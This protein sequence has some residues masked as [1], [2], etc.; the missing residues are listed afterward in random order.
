MGT[1][2][3]RMQRAL[4]LQD[5]FVLRAEAHLDHEFD[6][7][8]TKEN[9]GVQIKFATNEDVEHFEL[10][11][12]SNP[13]QKITVLR[14]SIDTGVRFV[15]LGKEVDEKPLVR[16][17]ITATFAADYLIKQKDGVDDEGVTAFAQNVVYHVWPY[18]RE[19]IHTTSGRLRL[20]GAIL[21]MFQP[22]KTATEDT[23]NEQEPLPTEY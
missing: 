15:A 17:E 1:P 6:P 16:A 5:V 2:L 9:L 7:K 13:N 23:Q 20:P 22:K 19:F 12:D 14:F 3:K 11:N 8:Y 18:W 10:S 4:A 21:P